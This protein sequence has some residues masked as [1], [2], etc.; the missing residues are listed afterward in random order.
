MIK[1]IAILAAVLSM[2]GCATSSDVRNAPLNAGVSRDFTAPYEQVQRL[3]LESV[4]GLNVD[5]KSAQESGDVYTIVFA[6]PMTAFSWGEVGR[7]AVL[8]LDPRSRVTV[9][10]EKRAKYQLTGT[11]E[12]EFAAA[13]FDGIEH[14]L[15]RR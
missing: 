10:S 11:D 8:D 14:A 2:A 6:K 3:A 4:Q 5:V 1:L 7:V 12:D 13:V 15:D 9:I